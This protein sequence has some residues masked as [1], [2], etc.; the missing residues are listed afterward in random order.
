MKKVFLMV[1]VVGMLVLAI[2]VV[3]AQ[4]V[5]TITYG[6]WMSEEASIINAEVAVF[7]KDNPDIKVVAELV[8]SSST[9]NYWTKL[10]TML[11]AGSC[12]DV[13]EIS[14]IYFKDFVNLG[15]LQDL[16][17][18]IKKDN[19]DLSVY[20]PANL[21]EFEING[22]Y[23]SLPTFMDTVG[24]Y[25]NIEDF[26]KAGLKLPSYDWTWSEFVADAKALTIKDSSGKVLRY[27]VDSYYSDQ[28]VLYPLGL[29]A[30]ATLFD[31][32]HNRVNFN[33]PQMIY[34]FKQLIDL[35]NAGYAAPMT[36]INQ[37]SNYFTSGTLAAMQLN[38]QWMFG[39]YTTALGFKWGF[40][41][42]PIIDP[43]SKYRSITNSIGPAM[44]S[45]SK[46]KEAAWKF[47]KFVSEKQGQTMLGESGTV[48]PTYKGLSDLWVNAF[49][50]TEYYKYAQIA[51][52][53]INLA[54]HYPVF[55][56]QS[57][58]QNI[59]KI[60]YTQIL[61]GQQPV[62][63]LNQLNTEI[64]NIIQQSSK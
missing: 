25:Y 61:A 28:T 26:E 10:Q 13:F 12:W 37:V 36:P 43:N 22:H 41:P 49:K 42:M 19:F 2:S 39:Y 44:W 64:N 38:G 9:G 16:T 20:P 15:V 48:I 33:S 24:V 21:G 51:A 34:V 62:D 18:Y 52:E 55:A 29:S 46:H 32:E 63:Y 56:G 8:A 5:T 23:Y 7:N 6:Y 54:Q 30:G 4:N 53:T 31:Y 40:A 11:S 57:Q 60:G 47:I 59:W 1:F 35:E 50:D 3:Q 45:G 27:G 58:W 14:P 17:P